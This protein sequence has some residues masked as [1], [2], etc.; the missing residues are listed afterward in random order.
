MR[1]CSRTKAGGGIYS[2][3]E[4]SAKR[5]DALKE[6]LRWTGYRRVLMSQLLNDERIKAYVAEI[7]DEKKLSQEAP[8]DRPALS[9]TIGGFLTTPENPSRRGKAAPLNT[10]GRESHRR[11]APDSPTA[12]PFKDNGSHR[13]RGGAANISRTGN[14]SRAALP[15][16]E[17]Y[18][19]T[20]FGG[21]G[22]QVKITPG[23]ARPIPTACIPASG[24][25][26]PTPPSLK[27]RRP[28]SARRSFRSDRR[29]N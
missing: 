29:G 17:G 15:R 13:S 14:S 8:I 1:R 9:G 22:W 11:A 23:P 10:N 25:P 2:Q 20:S 18:S 7:L 28:G 12:L 6:T 4:K 21:D 27:R 19:D 24:I 26:A 5:T 3:N 16:R